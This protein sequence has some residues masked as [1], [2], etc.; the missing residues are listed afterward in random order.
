MMKKKTYFAPMAQFHKLKTAKI[1]CGSMDGEE[2]VIDPDDPN[3]E[4]QW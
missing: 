4:E 2:K 1:I 3:T